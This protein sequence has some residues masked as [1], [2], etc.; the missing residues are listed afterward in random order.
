MDTGPEF[1]N[2]KV[3]TAILAAG[4]S[5]VYGRTGVPNDKPF[6]ERFFGTLR[7]F[8]A[9]ELPG[10]TGSSAQNLPAYDK[11]GMAAFNFEEL[12]LI[13][14]RTVVDHYQNAKHR[15]LLNETPNNAWKRSQKFGVVRPPLAHERRNATGL[16]VK[17]K[18]GKHGIWVLGMAFS[19]PEFLSEF[20]NRR[21]SKVLVKVD[22]TCL[23]EV[24]AK[25]GRK[26]FRLKNQFRSLAHHSVRS[27]MAAYKIIRDGDPKDN[28]VQE[29]ILAKHAE[30]FA[31][32]IETAVEGH[33]LPSAYISA[34]KLDHFEKNYVFKTRV[35][36]SP[37]SAASADVETFLSGG[38]GAGIFSADDCAAARSD[39]LGV[40]DGEAPEV[41]GVS[42]AA[43]KSAP[44]DV[45]TAATP[46]QS[47]TKDMTQLKGFSGAPKGNGYFT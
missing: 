17:R 11:E 31:N 21:E 44:R 41:N 4:G 9:D 27:I 33:G 14:I 36:K 40:P 24:T 25:I 20:Q 16:Q 26:S 6:K 13:L 7:S 19:S 39:G 42:P 45:A 10:K 1:F 46:A 30:R 28:A 34:Q 2:H 35:T 37:E 15:G 43:T 23:G 47:Q 3:Q 12:H 32:K 29:Y 8:C 38:S 18:I 5:F 22:S